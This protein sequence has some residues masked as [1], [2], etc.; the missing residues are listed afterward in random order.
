MNEEVAS[1]ALE[2]LPL[3]EILWQMAGK[4]GFI[5]SC[6]K[7]RLAYSVARATWVISRREKRT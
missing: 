2:L 6:H 7:L 3:L 1:R 4:I 5:S